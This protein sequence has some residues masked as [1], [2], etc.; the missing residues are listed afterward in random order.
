MSEYTPNP[1]LFRRVYGYMCAEWN[2][3]PAL[4]EFDRMI[5]RVK[6]EAWDEGY[7]QGGNDVGSGLRENELTPNPYLEGQ[8]DE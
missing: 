6:A 2:Q 4:A 7:W 3:A 5:A 8:D 1:D